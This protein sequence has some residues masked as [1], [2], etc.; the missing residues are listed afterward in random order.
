MEDPSFHL[1]GIHIL[2]VILE[3]FYLGLLLMCFILA[4]GNRPQGSKLGYTLAF[5]GFALIT[6]YMTVSLPPFPLPAAGYKVWTFDA[7]FS[8]GLKSI[9]RSILPCDESYPEYREQR[10]KAP[11]QSAIS[12]PTRSSVTSSSCFWQ[13]SGNTSFASVIFVSNLFYFF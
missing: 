7:H 8:L 3:Y 1:N 12:S 10:W 4:L 6:I 9:V 13:R 2:N 11:S 5:I